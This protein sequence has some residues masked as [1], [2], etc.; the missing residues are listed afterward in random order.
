LSLSHSFSQ[1]NTV[2]DI[3]CANERAAVVEWLINI[4]A[5]A[6]NVRHVA[7]VRSL[8]LLIVAVLIDAVRCASTGSLHTKDNH[9]RR[10]A[11]T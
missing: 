7:A 8:L 10:R 2:V 6:H 3:A 1:G 9:V 11:S 5:K 4:G